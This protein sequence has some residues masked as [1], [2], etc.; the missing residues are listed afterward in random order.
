MYNICHKIFKFFCIHKRDNKRERDGG[1][2]CDR[3]KGAVERGL[4]FIKITSERERVKG[5][6]E[7]ER[8]RE[9]ERGRG[10]K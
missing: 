9:R 3:E 4:N 1:R 5:M 7:R 8:E 10:M 2:E 6:K